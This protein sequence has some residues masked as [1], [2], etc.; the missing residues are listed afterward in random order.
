MALHSCIYC[1]LER[2]GGGIGV[3][4]SINYPLYSKH[5]SMF[6]FSRAL[7]GFSHFGEL[8]DARREHYSYVLD[9]GWQNISRFT[10]LM[11]RSNSAY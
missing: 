6:V 8:L 5:P 9:G 2:N 7:R 3:V 1:P 10:Y 11:I 4:T